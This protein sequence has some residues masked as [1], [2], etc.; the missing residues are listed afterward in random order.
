MDRIQEIMARA[1]GSETTFEQMT[2]R[3]YEQFKVDGLNATEGNR[4]LEDGYHCHVCKNK[5]YVFRVVDGEDG[6]FYQACSPCKCEEVRRSIM[7]MKRSGLKD[8]IKDYTF[9]KFIASENWQKAI[10]EAAMEYARNPEGWFFK[11]WS[12]YLRESAGY[13][14]A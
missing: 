8:I 12:T 14:Y 6:R 9:D 3:D 4:H 2:P 10:K 7:R 13:F 5:G 1:V 11:I